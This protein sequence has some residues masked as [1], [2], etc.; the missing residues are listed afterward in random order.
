MF[1]DFTSIPLL[2]RLK[3]RKGHGPK[4]I[5]FDSAIL[6]LE[7]YECYERRDQGIPWKFWKFL[8]RNKFLRSKT[9]PETCIKRWS[10]GLGKVTCH[11]PLSRGATL[12]PSS[13]KKQAL[14]SK[15]SQTTRGKG[16]YISYSMQ[17]LPKC[18]ENDKSYHIGAI[19]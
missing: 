10:A 8:W 18:C 11:L 7:N 19:S 9:N 16:M 6:V 3:A 1:A 15:C 2:K 14:F 12:W 13:D 5:W 17:Y 4:L